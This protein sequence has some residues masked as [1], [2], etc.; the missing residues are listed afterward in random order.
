MKA[1]KRFLNQP[2]KFWANV[3]SISQ[4]VG[5]TLRGQGVIMVPSIQDMVEALRSIGLRH[6]HIC[7]DR[8][9]PTGLGIDLVC[10]FSHR[11][12][13]LNEYVEPRLMDAEE[14]AKEFRTLRSSLKPKCPI[15]M[16]KQKGRKRKPAYLTGIVNMLIEHYSGKIECDYEPRELTTITSDGE[17]IRTLARWVD[18][19]FPNVV[20][21]IAVWEIKE[22]YYTTTFGSRVADGIYE[23]L[24]DGMELSELYEHEDIKVLHYL[25]VDSHYTWW[26]CG[27]SYLCRII[28]I[29]HMGYVDEVL[30]GREVIERLPDI[31][32]EWVRLAKRR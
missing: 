6:D 29:L 23:T 22:Y 8:Y 27:R 13:M 32:K 21:P 20:N 10:Y 2:P 5:Y 15:P 11:A 31:V 30:F 18:G 7:D 1:D 17:P 14:A 16:N 9:R 4:K 25:M 19:A 24:M 28:D 26:E 12:R 3:R